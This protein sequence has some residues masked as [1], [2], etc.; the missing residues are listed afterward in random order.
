[1][2]FQGSHKHEFDSRWKSFNLV[3]KSMENRL[4]GKKQHI[5]ALLIDRV[6][7]QH[8]LRTLTVE[9]CE[10]KKIHQD[11][12]RDLLRLSTSSYSQVRNKAQQT[13]LLPWEHITSVAEISF[14]WFWSSY[15]LINKMSLSSNSRVP[16]IVSLEITVVC[17]WQT[18]MIG[19]VLYRPGQQ[20]FLLGLAKQCPWKS[21]Q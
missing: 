2:Q 9:G 12:I 16:C 21:H 5:R 19:T 18:F 15:G 14:P 1:M 7:L 4:H 11:M 8:E 13:F 3:K 20:S 10:Y 17:A 6:M